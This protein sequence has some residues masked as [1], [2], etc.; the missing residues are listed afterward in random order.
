V[1][2]VV[3][4]SELRAVTLA[5]ARRIAQ[6]SAYT[7]ALGKKAFYRQLNLD[8]GPA[9][10]YA[11]QVMTTNALAHD[12]QEGMGAFLAKRQPIWKAR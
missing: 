10:E 6:A 5:L 11:G 9:Y 12:A 2:R 3:P 7:I 4:V 8:R 1:N